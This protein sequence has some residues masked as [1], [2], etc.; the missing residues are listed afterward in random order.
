MEVGQYYDGDLT[1]WYF[2]EDE[3]KVLI[4]KAMDEHTKPVLDML[5]QL[6]DFTERSFGTAIVGKPIRN[7]VKKLLEQY[8]T[9]SNENTN[10]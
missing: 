3:E 1:H 8:K 5:Q 9:Q 2:L 7:D 6:Y 4:Y 10:F